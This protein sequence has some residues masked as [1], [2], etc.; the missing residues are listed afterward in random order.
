MFSRVENPKKLVSMPT[1]KSFLLKMKKNGQKMAFFLA[2]K[3]ILKTYDMGRKIENF[4][5]TCSYLARV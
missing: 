3:V 2:Q 1:I 5:F 4:N